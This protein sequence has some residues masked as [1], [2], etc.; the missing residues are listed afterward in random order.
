VV[1]RA[2]GKLF[3]MTGLAIAKLLI[4]SVILADVDADVVCSLLST[5]SQKQVFK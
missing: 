5:A 2:A 1:C 3:Q 4:P